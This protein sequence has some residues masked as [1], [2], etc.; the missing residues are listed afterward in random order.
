MYPFL[1]GLQVVVILITFIAQGI[2]LSGDGS[3]EQK[4]M[5][6]FM[7]GSIVLNVGYYLEITAVSLDAAIVATKMQYLG[8]TFIPIF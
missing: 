4:L 1:T 3:R 2:L 6:L 5:S 7:T 8:V